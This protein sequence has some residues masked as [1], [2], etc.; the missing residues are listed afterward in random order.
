MKVKVFVFLLP[1]VFN[2]ALPFNIG[3]LNLQSV[4]I[5]NKTNTPQDI[6]VV[7]KK[8]DSRVGKSSQIPPRQKN[9]I[10]HDGYDVDSIGLKNEFFD[11]VYDTKKSTLDSHVVMIKTAG[12]YDVL[13]TL[14][15]FDA[16]KL[17]RGFDRVLG[18]QEWSKNRQL[19]EGVLPYQFLERL[20]R[21]YKKNIKNLYKQQKQPKIPLTIHQIWFGN[22]MPE[23]YQEWQS[24]WKQK[25]PDWE[26]ILWDEKKVKEEFPNGL[27]NQKTFDAAQNI[28]NYAK[29]ADVLRY[30]VLNKFGG[31]YIDCDAECFERFDAL[32]CAF[33]FYAGLEEMSSFVEVGNT[34]IGSRANHPVL[35]GVMEIVKS[36]EDNG[37]SLDILGVPD[38]RNQEIMRTLITTGPIALTKAIWNNINQKNNVDI[39]FPS[40]YLYGSH[41]DENKQRITYP[42]TLCR[43]YFCDTWIDDIK[44]KEES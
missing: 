27:Y 4:T 38:P 31:L 9:I 30:E 26:F 6:C 28:S 1:V 8:G 23:Q 21:L 32:H 16:L 17:D 18:I 14:D 7:F 22:P 42:A 19:P 36:Y 20:W 15:F 34:V 29:M 25:H 33:D 40:V 37:P 5:E 35:Q 41:H 11:L 2:F 10:K 13:I 12:K 43:H 44:I 24:E 3:K 39:I